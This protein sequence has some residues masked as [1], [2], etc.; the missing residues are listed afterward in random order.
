MAFNDDYMIP[1]E[2]D[3]GTVILTMDDD[4]ELECDIIAIYSAN[5]REYIALLADDD[6]EEESI[7]IYRFIDHGDDEAPEL[8]NIEDDDEYDAAADALDELLDEAEFYEDE[9]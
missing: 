7:L 4:T 9:E 8:V 1:E 3:L 2:D 6:E 5:D